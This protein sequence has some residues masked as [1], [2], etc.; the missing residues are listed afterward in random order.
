M[1]ADV[2]SE[3]CGSL[4]KDTKPQALARFAKYGRCDHDKEFLEVFIPYNTNVELT[5]CGICRK[6]ISKVYLA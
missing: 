1:R 6:R 3:E 2:Y 5:E 4:P